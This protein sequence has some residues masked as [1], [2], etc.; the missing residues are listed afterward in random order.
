MGSGAARSAARTRFPSIYLAGARTQWVLRQWASISW[1]HAEG[2]DI[3]LSEV[4]ETYKETI[5]SLD[6]GFFKV[7]IDRLTKAEVEL[8]RAMAKLGDGPYPMSDIAAAMG[9]KLS[10]LGPARAKI[11]KKGMIYSTDHG[12]LDFTVPL[13]AD[14]MRRQEDLS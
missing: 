11:I 10:S 7:R 1:N 13:F 12:F 4:Q 14:Y 5:A 2:A 9:R 3:S 6:D 8:V